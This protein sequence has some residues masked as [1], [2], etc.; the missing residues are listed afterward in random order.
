MD[1]TAPLALV[2]RGEGPGVRGTV[3]LSF[4]CVFNE[5]RCVD[6]NALAGVVPA[7]SHYNQ[8]KVVGSAEAREPLGQDQWRSVAGLHPTNILRNSLFCCSHLCLDRRS[9]MFLHVVK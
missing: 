3:S 7:P 2:L 9:R 1:D 4:Q 6:T 5:S 8:R